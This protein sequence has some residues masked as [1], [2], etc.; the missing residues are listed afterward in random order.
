M[1]IRDPELESLALGGNLIWQLSSN[2]NHPVSMIF[3]RK[4][5][6]GGSL[7]N[8]KSSNIPAGTTIWNLC[9]RGID[10]FQSHLYRVHGNGKMIFLWD[11]KILGNPPLSTINSLNEIKT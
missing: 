3:W 9:R 7:R 8:L 4:Y 2:K 5:L 10:K 11:D 6:K 1:Q